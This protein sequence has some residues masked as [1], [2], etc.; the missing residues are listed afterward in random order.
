[1]CVCV[2]VCVCVSEAKFKQ[3]SKVVVEQRGHLHVGCI[4]TPRPVNVS[5]MIVPTG[6][7][8]LTARAQVAVTLFDNITFMLNLASVVSVMGHRVCACA[9][10]VVLGKED[11]DD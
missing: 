7:Q 9:V 1:M 3:E 11:E 10:R 5:L 6:P 4:I 2:C 8:K